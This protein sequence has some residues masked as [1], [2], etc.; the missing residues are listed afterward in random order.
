MVTEI[1]NSKWQVGQKRNLFGLQSSTFK[2]SAL[3]YVEFVPLA[4]T[5]IKSFVPIIYSPEKLSNWIIL[6]DKNPSWVYKLEPSSF[7]L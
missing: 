7:C 1:I 4:P 2:F 6:Y 5:L 3:V